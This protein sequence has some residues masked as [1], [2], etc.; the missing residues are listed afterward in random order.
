[1]AAWGQA[2]W[3]ALLVLVWSGLLLLLSLDPDYTAGELLDH[4][5]AW[6]ES[7]VLYP[8]LGSEPPLRVL[9]YPPLVFLLARVLTG[10][11]TPALLAGRLVNALGL[12]AL[13][14]GVSW[15]ARARGARG[16]ALAGTVGLMGASF[17]VLYGA[18]QFHIELWAAAGTVWGFGLLYRAASW[19]GAALGGLVLALGCFA[20]QTQVV[21]SMLALGWIWVH[22]RRFAPAALA[23]FGAT[24]ALGA[25]AIT[26]AWGVEAWRHL[27]SYTVGV[28][29]VANLGQ[30]T[31]SHLAPWFILLAF[32]AHTA[33]LRGRRAWDDPVLWY[34]GGALIW[35]LSAA[36]IGS[37]YPYFLDVHIATVIW[38]GPRIFGTHTVRSR[39]WG[40]LLAT[41]IVAANLGVAGALAANVTRLA[42]TEAELPALCAR[43]SE[44]PR[45]I[46]EE[47]GLAR[48]CGQ[49]ALIHPFIT[50]S[51]AT[52]GLWNPAP[53]ERALSEGGYPVVVLPFDPRGQVT[54]AHE[55][56]WTKGEL[57][58]FRNAPV[59]ESMPTGRWAARW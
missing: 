9:N 44:E 13:V 31:L 23:A 49:P 5:Q 7:G 36:R 4:L 32:T 2:G 8:P 14:T 19:K 28:Y 45:M 55:Q 11:G 16:A 37:G 43:L 10:L 50:T 21:P 29:S 56:R 34:W 54:A 18:G 3:F 51:L 30:Q 38:V 57:A 40:W 39:V 12:L 27:V 26:A 25:S 6:R 41:Q 47:A 24:G 53:F 52:Q 58:A 33:W 48:A 42:R 59:V 20:K 46:A 15:W 1:M 22:R 17:P 35:S